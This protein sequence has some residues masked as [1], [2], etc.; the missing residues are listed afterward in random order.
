MTAEFDLEP[1]LLRLRTFL[2]QAQLREH[3]PFADIG[4]L[5]DRV[6]D[7]LRY[8]R[9]E[10]RF[11]SAEALEESLHEVQSRFPNFFPQELLSAQRHTT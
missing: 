9:L 4:W 1:W 3:A 11:R 6:N 10:D 7:T 5:I 8:T 2:E